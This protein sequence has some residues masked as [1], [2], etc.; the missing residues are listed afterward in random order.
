VN[1]GLGW[2]IDRNLNYDLKKPPLLA[3]ILGADGLGPTRREW[4]NFSPVLGLAWTPSSDGKSVIRAG[5]G[6]YYD[7][8][9]PAGLDTERAAHGSPGLGRQTYAGSAIPGL[10]PG[11][12]VLDFRANPT[13]FTGANLTTLLPA[14]R[15]CLAQR[16]A[17]A[18]GSVDA[19]QVTKMSSPTLGVLAAAQNPSASSQHVNAGMQREIT[20]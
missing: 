7:F 9:F 3:P 5:A 18:D 8:L 16:L 19:I 15:S 13:P 20:R 6:I 10:C 14:I 11:T 12:P 4:K 1:Y 2:S 17:N